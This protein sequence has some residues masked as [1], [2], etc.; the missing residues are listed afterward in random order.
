M[1][2][3]R[4]CRGLGGSL[5]LACT[6]NELPWR[7]ASN[8]CFWTSC[9]GVWAARVSASAPGAMRLGHEDRCQLQAQRLRLE[10]RRLRQGSGMAS[11]ILAY[12]GS[13]TA[14]WFSRRRH[15][16]EE[17]RPEERHPLPGAARVQALIGE[18]SA[19]RLAA[20]RTW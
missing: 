20:S 2:D 15:G 5:E 10:E 7:L 1:R 6:A 18:H 19:W 9:N 8:C 3:A 12:Y 4:R 16:H 17:E 14:I 13:D 11:A